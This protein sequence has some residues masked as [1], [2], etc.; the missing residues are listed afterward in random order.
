MGN[1]AKCDVITV[2][3][4]GCDAESSGRKLGEFRTNL[5][6]LPIIAPITKME[7]DDS[8]EM[9]VSSFQTVRLQIQEVSNLRWSGCTHL[10]GRSFHYPLLYGQELQI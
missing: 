7:A 4:I 6:S 5:L 3:T 8:T 9:H 1:R 10:I 2:V